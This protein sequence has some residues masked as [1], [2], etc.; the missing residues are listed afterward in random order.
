MEVKELGHVVLWVR[1]LAASRHFYRD[2]LG[3]YELP[4]AKPDRVAYSSGRTHHELYL[5]QV[6][7][8]PT[9]IP[10]MP[11]LGMYHFGL[12]IG[13]SDEELEA[14]RQRLVD[15]GVEIVGQAGGNTTHSLDL[16]DPDG[17]EVELFIDVQ[18]AVWQERFRDRTPVAQG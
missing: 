16:L 11:R 7:G 5:I 14:A 1:D 3:F 9:P 4:Q 17:N 12:K 2:V 18:P 8:E 15:E 10:P 13:E 6:P